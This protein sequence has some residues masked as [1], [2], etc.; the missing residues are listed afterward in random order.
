MEFVRLQGMDVEI[1][2]RP[3]SREEYSRSIQNNRS[4]LAK[5]GKPNDPI[6]EVSATE[7]R[8][9]AS[10]MGGRLPTMEEINTLATQVKHITSTFACK[11]WDC[12]SEWLDCSPEWLKGDN[13]LNCIVHPAWLRRKNGGSAR[14]SI[15]NQ[16]TPYVTF[17]LVRDRR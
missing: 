7:A 12:L 16:R 6:T 11:S 8:E 9:F 13:E 3:I 4:D 2:L 10:R 15:P 14:G 17:R 1:S 5:N